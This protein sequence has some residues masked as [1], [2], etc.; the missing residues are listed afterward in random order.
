MIWLAALVLFL[1]VYYL[2]T[3]KPRGGAGEVS[4]SPQLAEKSRPRKAMSGNA[5]ALMGRL[6]LEEE[7]RPIT[8][9]LIQDALD[10]DVFYGDDVRRVVSELQELATVC[11]IFLT[12]SDEEEE[13]IRTKVQQLLPSYPIHRCLFCGS[14]VG[15]TAI[16]RQVGPSLHIEHEADFCLKLKPH[17]KN[18]VLVDGARAAEQPSTLSSSPAKS[19]ISAGT[20]AEVPSIAALGAVLQLQLTARA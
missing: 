8:V 3:R 6:N 18:I 16:V 10:V 7:N 2:S 9:S 20:T 19:V 12:T 1:C 11:L 13:C 14:G 4:A 17:I 15:K 5:R